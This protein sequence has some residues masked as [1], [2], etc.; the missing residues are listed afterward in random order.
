MN[1]KIQI[2]GNDWPT[3]DGTGIRDFI[4]VMDLAEAHLAS[5]EYIDK[6]DPDIFTFNIGRGSGTTVLEL[7]RIFEK[8]NKCS[9]P[10]E[11][12][13]RRK[14]D[15]ASSIANISFA[16]KELDWSPNRSIED[17]CKMDGN[18]D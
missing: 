17:A 2:Y 6:S 4:H 9:I 18:G 12:T 15:V 3:H 13:E 11:F 8:V 14:G 7:I 10:F 5:M 1:V 16:L